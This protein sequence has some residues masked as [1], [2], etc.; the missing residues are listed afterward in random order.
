MQKFTNI[1]TSEAN[2]TVKQKG[3][4][5]YWIS[6][7]FIFRLFVKIVLKNMLSFPLYFLA[8]WRLCHSDVAIP[9]KNILT[10]WL[11]PETYFLHV[12]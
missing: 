12:V 5:K 9:D 6:N 7:V 3:G 8:V 2:S 10:F 1:K 11:L 4:K